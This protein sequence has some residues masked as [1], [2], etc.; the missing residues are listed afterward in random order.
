MKMDP[1]Q[2]LVELAEKP[3]D[4]TAA[5]NRNEH[6]QAAF[7]ALKQENICLK[8]ENKALRQALRVCNQKM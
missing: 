6:Q 4:F 8:M 5:S 7:K 2:A 3:R 1:Q